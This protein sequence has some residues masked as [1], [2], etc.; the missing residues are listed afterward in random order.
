MAITDFDR[1]EATS[2]LTTSGL[3]L[4]WMQSLVTSLLLLALGAGCSQA[5]AVAT[6][7][8]ANGSNAPAEN[9]A[10]TATSSVSVPRD[11]ITQISVINALML[12][13]YDG[14]TTFEELLRYGD[15]GV[16]TLNQL[17]GE[18]IILDGQGYQVHGDGTIDRVAPSAKT[19]FAV[20]TPFDR[21]EQQKL[22]QI[23]SLEWLDDHLDEAIGHPNKFIAVRIHA[24][25]ATITLR[26][27]KVQSPPYRPLG[28]VAK[29]Q[30]VW[31]RENVTGTLIGIRC[32]KWVQGLNVPGYHWHFLADDLSLGGHVLKCAAGSALAEY[33]VCQEWL[34]RLVD[35]PGFD[36]VNLNQDLNR[37]LRRVE[38]ARDDEESEAPPNK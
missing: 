19:P 34:V 21:A 14:I 4:R 22:P 5:P 10:Q 6:Q 12:G 23:E 26:S 20:V 24:N 3:V 8:A 9:G 33:D 32:P 28:V 15:F 25:F 16:G 37:E 18:L 17:D 30:S 36:T 35:A 27:V 13:H 2:Q 1:P 29:E 38:S 7:P 31:T 11:Q